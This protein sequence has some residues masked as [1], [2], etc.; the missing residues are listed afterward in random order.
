MMV[1]Q[2][3]DRHSVLYTHCSLQDGG[4][5]GARLGLIV[6]PVYSL[7][8]THTLLSTETSHP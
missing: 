6:Q 3:K 8:Y 2:K 4:E 1:F 7:E 5:W